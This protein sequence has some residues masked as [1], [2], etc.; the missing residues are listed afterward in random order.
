MEF[1]GIYLFIESTHLSNVL[2]DRLRGKGTTRAE[3]AQGTPTQSHMSPSI[4]VYDDA[5]QGLWY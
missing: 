5:T 2:G 4:L 3:D 1:Q